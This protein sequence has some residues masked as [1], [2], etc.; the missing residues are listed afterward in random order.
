MADRPPEDRE[1]WLRYTRE[2]QAHEEA[3]KT[4]RKGNGP[5][6]E[7][8]GG[9]EPPRQLRVDIGQLNAESDPDEVAAIV[10]R[11][12][13]STSDEIVRE[14]LLR[15]V[16]AQTGTPVGSMRKHI[17]QAAKRAK[18]Q[19]S[20]KSDWHDQL[21]HNK[22]GE[23]YATAANVLIALRQA[24]EWRGVLA[25]DE[26]HQQPMVVSKP[27]WAKEWA[28][29]TTF[30]DA[31]EART[32]VWMQENG[33]PL[34]RI[35]AVRQALAV[36][37]DNNRF[38]PVREYLDGLKWDGSSRL[39]RWLTYYLGVE[40]I[41]N[42][43]GPIGKCWLISAVARIYQPGCAA[44]YCLILE[45][46]QDLGKST[47]LEVLGGEWFTDDMAE[48][49]T[50]DSAMQ[51]GNAWIVEL[52]ELD[53]TRRA[54][55]AAVKA[56]TSRK[57]DRFRKP[58][59]RL[60]VSQERQCVMAGTINPGADYLIDDTGNVRFWPVSCIKIDIASLTRDRDQLWAEAVYRFKSG[61]K[62]WLE[63]EQ[64]VSV[65]R[66]Q[67]DARTQDD[68]WTEVI[69]KY[70]DDRPS[71]VAITTTQ[72]LRAALYIDIKDHDKA[73]QS[74]VGIIMRR[75]LGWRGRKSGAHRWFERHD[76]SNTDY[77]D[78]PQPQE[79]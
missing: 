10:D 12:A 54:H 6:R 69:R 36:A 65:A 56:F 5:D 57:V 42:Y 55:I 38:H 66:A 47:A 71:T 1:A 79:N 63:D 32:L 37:I 4:R 22:D 76:A 11:I 24:P 68:S 46:D 77:P 35:E 49:G 25:L 73:K 29:P 41:D 19:T 50:K 67:Q 78:T 44:K 40:P 13:K 17:D 31:D 7:H 18:R 2:K 30:A 27:P 61:E 28:G 26:F 33:L 72:I 9:E 20:G 58:F 64:A 16:K 74:R 52:A 48:L 15:T 8:A 43:T 70:L 14:S 45:G 21:S 53:S 3:E 51:A 60:V 34:C 23:P 62:W 75:K 59:G 39:D